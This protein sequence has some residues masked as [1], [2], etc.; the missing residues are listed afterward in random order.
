MFSRFL[1]LFL[2]LACAVAAAE[3]NVRAHLERGLTAIGDPVQLEIRISGGARRIGGPPEISVDGL[4]IQYETQSHMSSFQFN[5]GNASGEVTTILI[6]QVVPQRNGSFTIPPVT[7][8]VDGKSYTT[9][10]VSLNVA[11]S[12]ESEGESQFAEIVVPKKTL[13]VGEAIPIEMRLYV[14]SDIRWQLTEM[15]NIDGEGFT[16]QKMP[17]P[18][19]KEDPVERN[20]KEYDLLI[21]KT[22]I[23]PIHAGD[24]TIGPS[25]IPF[26]AQVPRAHRN[27][28]GSRSP[29]GFLGDAFDDQFFSVQQKLTAKAEAVH[30]TVKQL[31]LVGKPSDF[32][33]AVGSFE[34]SAEGAPTQVKVG[35][36]ITMR[37]KVS[38]HGNFDRVSAPVVGDTTG[39]RTYPPSNTFTAEDAVNYSGTKTF[40][41]A[42]IPETRKTAMPV[43]YF[44]FFDPAKGK[45]VTLN[46]EAAPLQVDDSAPPAPSPVA[47]ATTT[48]AA[49]ESA[50]QPEDIVG[51]RYDRDEP[52]AFAPLYERR[53]FWFAQGAVAVVLLGLGAFRIR[54]RPDAVALQKAA[55]RQEKDAA[56]Q[57]LRRT[58]LGH[59]DFFDAAARVAQ[60]DTAL[61]TGAPVSGIDAAAVRSSAHLDD[62]A[63]ETIDEIFNSRAELHYAGGGSGNGQVSNSDRE[64]VLEVLRQLEKDHARN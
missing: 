58:D 2:A 55:L 50:P 48:P 1:F 9:K 54:R 59:A 14:R 41:E 53:E 23:A 7:V 39:W 49:P 62:Q 29:F 38:G 44:S 15:P 26:V 19:S 24:L 13:Y 34:F 32:S 21:F 3:P 12:S 4:D 28:G 25:E 20:G 64:R 5:N 27:G 56:W 33:G 36:P 6:Y 37:L 17:E 63:V 35:D 40:E 45:Y 47:P 60:I 11:P 46:S 18:H 61:A 43:F 30:L 42:V 57:Q 52:R 10:Q 8:E 51:I 22:V 16:K 31:P